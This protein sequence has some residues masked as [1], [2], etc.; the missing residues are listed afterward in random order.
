MKVD[1]YYWGTQ[2][3]MI[4]SQLRLLDE[5]YDRLTIRTVDVSYDFNLAKRLRMFFPFLLV[6]DEQTRHFSPLRKEFLE[7]LSK[8]KILPE[9]PYRVKLNKEPYEREILP[10]TEATIALAGQCTGGVCASDY[11]EKFR[12]FKSYGMDTLGFVNAEKGK[13]LGGAEY[14]PSLIVPYDIPRSEDTAFITCLYL[15]SEERDYKSAPLRRLE[16]L[17]FTRYRKILAISEE[18]GVFP[19]GDLS[20]FQRVGYLDLGLISEE[21][22]LYRLH[23]VEK[24]RTE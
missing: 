11:R 22:G 4:L 12:L 8:G 1:F 3:P 19:N 14:A 21:P 7:A 15:S 6:I 16:D 24:T 23:L 9:N 5:F 20:Y 17:L 13:L 18:N 10:I 2:C